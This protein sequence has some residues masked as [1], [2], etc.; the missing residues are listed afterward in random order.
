MRS[1]LLSIVLLGLL[2]SNV[3]NAMP[4]SVKTAKHRK[5]IK[6][7]SQAEA[8]ARVKSNLLQNGFDTAEVESFF[9]DPR[10]EIYK[11]KKILGGSFS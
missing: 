1:I 6:H 5:Q 3:C 9:A 2:L 8:F 10:L 7:I 11:Q 4:V